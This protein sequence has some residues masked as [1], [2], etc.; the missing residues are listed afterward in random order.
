MIAF[1][2]CKINLGLNVINKRED[3]FHNLETIF[4]P[5][6]WCDMLEIVV[7][8]ES[9]KGEVKFMSDGLTIEGNT[10]NNLV[11]KAYKL[12]HQVY[13]LPAV[14]VFL[15]KKIPM[16]AGLGGGSSDAAYTL[17]LLND[18][19]SLQLTT[20]ELEK[21]AAQLGSDCAYFIKRG[22]QLAKGRGELLEPIELNLKSYFLCL[23]KPDIH[24]STAQAFS[25]VKKRGDL[26][27]SLNEL[28]R[29]PMN[30]WRNVIQNDF[31]ESVFKI[32]PELASIKNN[33]YDMGSKYAAMSGSGSTILGLFEV[34][35]DLSN[36]KKT[37]TVFTCEL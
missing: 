25:G 32:Y 26:V 9:S 36:L 31:E 14:K 4:Y 20:I 21:Y 33:L 12:F 19:F 15:F 1:P 5:V 30:D 34:L 28:I 35:P 13:D 22:V 2:C 37:Y 23:I 11:I 16:G 24:V 10:E 6:H 3:G 17:L 29:L 27:T 7:D 18:L 8:N